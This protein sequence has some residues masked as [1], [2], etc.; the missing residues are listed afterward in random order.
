M[1][2][3]PTFCA[4]LMMLAVPI[5]AR[6]EAPQKGT[7][8]LAGEAAILSAL[9]ARGTQQARGPRSQNGN[10]ASISQVGDRNNSTVIQRGEANT[11]IVSIQGGS[12]NTTFQQQSGTQNRSLV[13]ITDGD[14]NNVQTRQTGANNYLGLILNNVDNM[15]LNYSQTG[16]GINAAGQQIVIDSN[17]QTP[18]PIVI[19]QTKR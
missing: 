17:A 5:A 11:A 13:T 8:F 15:N 12:D 7:Q 18:M 9:K 19:Q 3:V 1:S 2:F 4:A 16:S 14:R 10:F 6:A